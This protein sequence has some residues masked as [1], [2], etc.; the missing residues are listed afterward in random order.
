MI[1][2]P[3]VCW[4]FILSSGLSEVSSGHYFVSIINL[5]VNIVGSPVKGLAKRAPS[6]VIVVNLLR[7]TSWKPP[8]SYLH[9]MSVFRY[10]MKNLRYTYS[11]KIMF[12]ALEFMGASCLVEDFK[13]RSEVEMVCVV[14]NETDSKR[15]DL[16]G[17]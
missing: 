13:A 8:L 7:E 2:A 4:M 9:I 6:S 12:P 1:S 16:L 10:L 5:T 11:Q 14:E 3:I 17:G 15:L